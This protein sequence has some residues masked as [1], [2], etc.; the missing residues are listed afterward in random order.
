MRRS[1]L[2]LPLVLAGSMIYWS[3]AL[4][5][6]T[7]SFQAF[8]ADEDELELPSPSWEEEP[9]R[10]GLMPIEDLRPRSVDWSGTYNLLYTGRESV[11]LP[12]LLHRGSRPV[13]PPQADRVGRTAY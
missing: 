9:I 10:V 3:V 7:L 11:T 5:L 6:S 1:L 2:W 12:R 8:V 13:D 4:G